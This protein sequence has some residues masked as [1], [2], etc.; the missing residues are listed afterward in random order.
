MHTRRVW[1]QPRP[2]AGPAGRR[3]LRCPQTPGIAGFAAGRGS[4]AAA[5][6]GGAGK[7]LSAPSENDMR[8]GGMR[9]P[10]PCRKDNPP[11]DRQPD[12]EH[13]RTT[14]R[15]GEDPCRRRGGKDPRRGGTAHH[16]PAGA[17]PGHRPARGP[18]RRPAVRTPAH[19]GPDHPDRRHRRGAGARRPARD[20]GRRGEAP[21]RARRP[22]RQLP[23]HRG[24]DVDGS[25]SRTGPRRVP[26]SAPPA[27]R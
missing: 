23:R 12:V 5:P 9:G 19:R 11:G 17:H 15:P 20:R 27:S 8:P 1:P 13:V 2:G 18:L 3:A 26:R 14:Q 4:P 16:L 22:H 25:R 6:P 21:R 7:T 10:N 24:P